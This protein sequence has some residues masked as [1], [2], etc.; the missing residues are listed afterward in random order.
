MNRVFQFTSAA[1]LAAVLSLASGHDAR[2]AEPP[3][4]LSLFNRIPE[5]PASAE[6][7]AQ[8]VDKGGAIVHPGLL[9]LRADLAAHQR[10]VEQVQAANAQQHQAQGAVVA[11]NMAQGMADVGIDM[12]RM[13]RDPAYAQA[14][15]ER[16]KK[17]SPQELMAMSQKMNQ[18]LN[19]DPRYR[20]AA[21][22][23][24]DD[25]PAARAAAEAG[26][27]YVQ[28]QGTRM[29]AHLALWREAD[30]AV[31]R[32]MK[33]PLAAPGPKPAME[34][35]NIGCDRG[36][37]AQWGAYAAKV[38]PLM[39]ARDT[40]AL[41]IRRAALQRDRAAVAEGL[42]AADRHLVATRYGA[43]SNSQV[44]RMH[45][46]NY[47]GAAVA[48]LSQLLDRITDSVKSAAGVVHCGKQIV[49]AP[50]AVCH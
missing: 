10:A 28:G 19:Q 36:C 41:R 47:D 1:A 15:Q 29:A 21:R 26:E 27:A 8:W 24:V 46:V 34:W 16:M 18:P 25:S 22:D 32:V 23:M 20:N 48:E 7:A 6:Q 14:V 40:E 9:A 3:S 35:E 17:M 31:Q 42:K 11:E 33:K 50:H 38:L 45:I 49:L 43:A 12:A 39:I 13:Q 2:A 5:L 44:N 30:E 37:Q 4:L